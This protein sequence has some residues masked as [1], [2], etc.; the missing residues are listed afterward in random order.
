MPDKSSKKNFL[1]SFAMG[2]KGCLPSVVDSSEKCLHVAPGI[3]H[4]LQGLWSNWNKVR[5]KVLGLEAPM[6]IRNPP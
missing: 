5:A 1:P 3:F 6:P 2:K 4:L